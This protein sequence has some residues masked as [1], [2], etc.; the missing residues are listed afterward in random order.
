MFRRSQKYLPSC[1]PSSERAK[2]VAALFEMASSCDIQRRLCTEEGP[3]SRHRCPCVCGTPA[4]VFWDGPSMRDQQC[5]LV[6]S[7]PVKNIKP[8][9]D[10]LL[11]FQEVH[12]KSK[13]CANVFC[14]AGRECAVN[15]KGEPSCLC[16]EVRTCRL[17][18]RKLLV[19]FFK[20]Y[21]LFDS[22]LTCFLFC[23]CPQSCKPHK[24][25]VCGSN[26]KTYRNHCELHRDACLTGLKIQVAHD[27]HC[28]GTSSGNTSGKK[29]IAELSFV[30]RLC[31]PP[32]LVLK[33]HFRWSEG[34]FKYHPTL[35]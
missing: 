14:G 9:G 23:F 28:Q 29:N 4:L 8:S 7:Q 30:F 13:V 22:F 26:S 15:E 34:G 1:C 11:L 33:T 35:L 17:L 10:V 31:F 32:Q 5:H 18:L 2:S 3:T 16:I 6:C 19:V 25:S 24:R 20:N 12:S 27:G 21:A